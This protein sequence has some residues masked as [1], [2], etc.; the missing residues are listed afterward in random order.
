MSVF[1]TCL[2]GYTDLQALLHADCGRTGENAL[3]TILHTKFALN[4]CA[5][6]VTGLKSKVIRNDDHIEIFMQ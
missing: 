5:I 1:L 6:F 3:F 4:A 2:K